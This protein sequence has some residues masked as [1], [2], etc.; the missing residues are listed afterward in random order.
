MLKGIE[1]IEEVLIGGVRLATELRFEAEKQ[2]ASFAVYNFQGSRLTLDGFGM[3]QEA[4]L[5]RADFFGVPGEYSAVEARK[6]LERWAI[7]K[8]NHRRIGFAEVGR[9]LGVLRFNAEQGA[10]TEELVA[11][12]AFDYVLNR[13]RQQRNEACGGAIQGDQRST[14]AHELAEIVDPIVSDA[15]CIFTRDDADAKAVCELFRR[16]VR[17]DDHVVAAG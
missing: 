17:Q 4:A 2:D 5:E 3:Q 16:H 15:A 14:L 10:R 11:L 9:Q 1:L 13:Q 7:L 6:H 12:C 8:E